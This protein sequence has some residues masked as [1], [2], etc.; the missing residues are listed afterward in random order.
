MNRIGKG[1][2]GLLLA[3]SFS[4]AASAQSTLYK[5]S[6]TALVGSTMGGSVADPILTAGGSMSVQEASG[7]G[8]EVDFGFANDDNARHP[9]ADLTTAMVGVN[10]IKPRGPLR[11]LA[12]FSA[13]VIGVHGCLLP[14]AAIT[15]TW[16]FAIGA[17]TGL[18]YD[19]TDMFA[20]GG[21][22][23]YFVAPGSHEGTSRP[24]NFR[25]LRAAFS[26]TYSW[27]IVP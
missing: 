12:T 27:A 11:P 9:A 25:F 21:E 6:V 17:G 8:A 16:N 18:R 5:G 7:W 4:G 22:V 10:W 2:A 19:L 3:L 20:V 26:I 1:A 14:C 13:G 24:E 23:R 15:S